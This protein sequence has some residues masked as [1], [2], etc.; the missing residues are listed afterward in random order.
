MAGLTKEQIAKRNIER[1][2]WLQRSLP[3]RKYFFI[4]DDYASR[5]RVWREGDPGDVFDC[6]PYN[7]PMVGDDHEHSR[8]ER[9]AVKAFVERLCKARPGSFVYGEPEED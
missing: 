3:D 4:E 2:E 7:S 1:A 8:I 6:I 5:F 9:L